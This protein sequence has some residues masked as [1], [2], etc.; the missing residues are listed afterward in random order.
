ME[1]NNDYIYRFYDI[2]NVCYGIDPADPKVKK[3]F[4]IGLSGLIYQVLRS[5]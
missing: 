4:Q 2:N 5:Q 3:V 1:A